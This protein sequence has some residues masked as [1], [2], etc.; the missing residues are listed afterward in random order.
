VQAF[1]GLAN[2]VPE[3][4]LHYS[5]LKEKVM[6][7]FY[8]VLSCLIALAL[9]AVPTTSSAQSLAFGIP[10]FSSVDGGVDSI[11]LSNLSFVYNVPM[12]SR[13]GRGSPPS[14]NTT[15][16]SQN[17][18]TGF[19]VR[20]H[21]T[22]FLTLAPFF[23][24]TPPI[25]YIFISQSQN[26]CFGIPPNP[27]TPQFFPVTKFT[28]YD[29]ANGTSHP[30]NSGLI[31]NGPPQYCTYP[32]SVTGGT[33]DQSGLTFSASADPAPST[34]LTVSVSLPNGTS[35]VPIIA[36]ETQQLPNT[37]GLA[38]PELFSSYDSIDSNG[39]IV[40]ESIDS[41]TFPTKITDTL[42]T[43]A[44]TGSAGNISYTAPSGV[45]ASFSYS[46]TNFKVQ[47]AWGCPG[48][49]EFSATSMNLLTKLALPDG[50][51]YQITYEPTSPGSQNVTGRISSMR[52]PT[53]GTIFY[54]YT[55]GDTG[56]GI[57][58]ADG[59]TAGFNR[60]TPDGTWKYLRSNIV[61]STRSSTT[62]ITDPQ[63]NNTVVNFS[64]NYETQRQVYTGAATGTPL[65]TLV[66]CYNGNTSNCAA[67]QDVAPNF[68]EITSSAH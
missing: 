64:G 55:G 9:V 40:S 66:T 38:F 54:T 5:S 27:E 42:G 58:C 67:A 49:A 13:A 7:R 56:K 26:E 21:N 63:G 16:Q 12:F 31:S 32:N 65:E 10:P 60:T 28:T 19:D 57:V 30:L 52:L 35:L 43:A 50:S 24:G 15:L 44:I 3:P 62:T 22:W 51:F 18:S 68:S 34:G 20:G 23:V 61:T 59:S 53:G 37:F 29:D 25:G 11:N 41:N 14:V 39:N 33:L 45:S 2:D 6:T 48:V 46:S 1:I 17:W 36:T 47:T 4:K 8:F